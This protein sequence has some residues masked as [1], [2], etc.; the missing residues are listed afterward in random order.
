MPL[1]SGIVSGFSGAVGRE[2]EANR[3]EQA[4]ID[5]RELT[6]LSLLAKSDDPETQRRAFGAFAGIGKGKG[7]PS[8]VRRVLE[9]P[10]GAATVSDLLKFIQ[11]PTTETQQVPDI[12]SQVTQGPFPGQGEAG[13]A[14]QTLVD[15]PGAGI[16]GTPPPVQGPPE[17]P[18]AQAIGQPPPVPTTGQEVQVPRQ[19]FLSKAETAGQTE[20]Q[21][22]EGLINGL[23]A[24][25]VQAGTPEQEAR[26]RAINIVTENLARFGAQGQLRGFLGEVRGDQVLA[27]DPN[28]VD[29]DGIPI[30]PTQFY[31]RQA[32]VRG[33]PQ[34][35]P[36]RPE[37]RSA[38]AGLEGTAQSLNFANFAEIAPLMGTEFSEMVILLERQ[39]AAARAGDITAEQQAVITEQT[40]RRQLQAPIGITAGAQQGISPR[41]SVG[42]FEGI[43]RTV[44]QAERLEALNT[45]DNSL[46]LFEQ[47]LAANFGVDPDVPL[48]QLPAGFLARIRTSAEQ[49][50][51]G[52]QG[53]PIFR[54][55]IQDRNQLIV[56][57]ARAL[58]GQRGVL[59]DIDF[60]NAEQSVPT[61]GMW[62]DNPRAAFLLLRRLKLRL[63][64]ERQ[65]IPGTTENRQGIGSPPPS[66][67]SPE[68][69]QDMDILRR[70]IRPPQ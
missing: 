63:Q 65:L 28:A 26:Q 40:L 8:F 29:A 46:Q 55:L 11:T 16:T 4:A 27:S 67:S 41:T 9:T 60:A 51:A 22:I 49:V 48:D 58:S 69:D 32:G 68:A 24:Q 15:Q 19:L 70:E 5:E 47:S 59:S 50:L 2:R 30:D 31:R 53:D 44:T 39:R 17:I 64:L 18:A 38:G 7:K 25:M 6:I 37:E 35:F 52:R 54:A 21:E 34:L 61:V 10:E 13:I 3:K 66:A 20:Q 33:E 36:I 42:E 1:L 57:V 14:A 62:A 43:P 23:T 56:P 12:E 45:L